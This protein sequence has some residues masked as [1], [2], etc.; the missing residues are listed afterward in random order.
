[1]SSCHNLFVFYTIKCVKEEVLRFK[2]FRLTRHFPG[3]LL[4]LKSRY[5]F[6]GLLVED[7]R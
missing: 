1:M 3:K 5:A 4:P 6:L 7:K 2:R